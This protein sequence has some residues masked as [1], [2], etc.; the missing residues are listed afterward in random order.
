METDQRF[1]VRMKI[2]VN[3]I[4]GIAFIVQFAFSAFSMLSMQ[5]PITINEI[6]YNNMLL[7][8][9]PCSSII[10]LLFLLLYN[11]NY[12]FLNNKIINVFFFVIGILALYIHAYQLFVL[13]DLILISVV[14]LL[15]DCYVI[16]R[17]IRLFIK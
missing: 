13:H 3:M 15:I 9:L 4:A 16:I 6:F 10:V 1:L 12:K 2:I 17:V 11:F 14:L 5:K 7:V 8:A